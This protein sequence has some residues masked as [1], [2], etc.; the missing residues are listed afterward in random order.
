MGN[1]GCVGR[2][3]S[4]LSSGLKPRGLWQEKNVVLYILVVG[5]LAAIAP[6]CTALSFNS[7][8]HEYFS[9]LKVRTFGEASQKWISGGGFLEG[10]G[11]TSSSCDA[12]NCLLCSH[13]SLSGKSCC[14]GKIII[15]FSPLA[16]ASS[17]FLVQHLDHNWLGPP[18]IL[19][20]YILSRSQGVSC[21][22][23]DGIIQLMAV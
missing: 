15:I 20:I 16:S 5:W 21:A 19:Q 1:R 12:N 4:M 9:F 10:N 2:H 7:C 11:G 14:Q 8:V 3:I 23:Q 17:H 6:L 13:T 22:I 18:D